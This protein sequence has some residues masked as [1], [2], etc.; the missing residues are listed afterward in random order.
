MEQCEYHVQLVT[1]IAVIKNDLTYIKSKVC[2]HVEEGEKQGGFRDRLVI[3]E[4]DISALKKAKWIT[5]I[6]AGL[7]GGLVSQLT[8]EVFTWL[9]RLII[10]R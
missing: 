4:Q 6:T 1:D 5:A 9:I 3:V 10:P 2:S 7:I 8:P